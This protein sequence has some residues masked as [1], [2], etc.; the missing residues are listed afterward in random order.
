MNVTL[1]KVYIEVDGHGDDIEMFRVFKDIDPLIEPKVY[2]KITLEQGSFFVHEI[3]Q[4]LKENKI[5]LY[6]T[7]EIPHYEF[8][9]DKEAFR[10]KY[11]PKLLKEDWIKF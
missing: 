2:H 1:V 5:Y 3:E 7:T 10:K 4:N 6:E 9:S 8:W 11:L